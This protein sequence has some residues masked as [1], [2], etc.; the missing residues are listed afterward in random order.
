MDYTIRP[1]READ[2]P[3]LVAIE[4]AANT[5][6]ADFEGETSVM[7][8]AKHGTYQREGRSWVAA[9]ANDEPVGFAVACEVDGN[10]HL[11]EIDVHPEHGRRG[12]GR[13]LVE[14]VCLWARET[15]YSS[16]T[17]TTERDIPW[18]AP[19]Y[20]KLG[21]EIVPPEQWT[22]G[23]HQRFEF[24]SGGSTTRVLMCRKL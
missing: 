21:F 16:L 14:H 7:S 2:F 5:L 10:G 22:P 13:A 9:D 15:G 17:L 3:K 4:E 12:I 24:E 6:F 20:A 23:E 1:T 8:E 11:A 18:N 19:F